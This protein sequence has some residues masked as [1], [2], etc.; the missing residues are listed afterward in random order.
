MWTVVDLP[1]VLTTSGSFRQSPMGRRHTHRPV[2]ATNDQRLDV[3][4]NR[5]LNWLSELTMVWA[6]IGDERSSIGDVP[7]G[8]GCGLAV[9]ASTMRYGLV[10]LSR[11]KE[12]ACAPK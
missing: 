3:G 10:P 12:R 6:R 9:A 7:D 5:R 1:D 4:L 2:A 11:A 8:D